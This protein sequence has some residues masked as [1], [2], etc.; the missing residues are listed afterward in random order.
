MTRTNRLYDVLTV[1]TSAALF[2]E[3]PAV[4]FAVFSYKQFEFFRLSGYIPHEELLIA[5]RTGNITEIL[6]APLV[7]LN[8]TS[9][10][11]FAN[12]Y[13]FT[14]GA[15]IASLALGGLAGYAIALQ[16]R[17]RLRRGSLGVYKSISA[18]SLGM[19]VTLATSSA[20]LL[21]CHGGTKLSGEILTQIG[22][23][24]MVAAEIAR[25]SPYIQVVLLSLLS[26]YCLVLYKRNKQL[27]LLR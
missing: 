13:V 3:T 2:V 1:A 11:L 5:L 14:L 18:L 22:F 4:I 25:A 17:A 27:V 16:A 24:S 10:H 6:A 26:V 7:S 20:G 23:E 12:V 9:G 15:V 8:M 19:V 21:G